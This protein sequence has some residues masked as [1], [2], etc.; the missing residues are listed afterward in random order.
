MVNTW[1]SFPRRLGLLSV[2]NGESGAVYCEGGLEAGP[3]N[4]N[5]LFKT[6]RG[7]LK[8]TLCD[9]VIELYDI[10]TVSHES[11]LLQEPVGVD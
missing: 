9:L 1:L 7:P 6:L 10:L 8:F 2:P 3:L 5:V 11:K 4:K